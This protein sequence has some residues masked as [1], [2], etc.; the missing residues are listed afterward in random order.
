LLG[1]SA[2]AK[3]FECV[4]EVNECRAAALLAA[5]RPDR[6]DSK[7][8]QELAAEVA[9]LPDAPSPESSAAMLRP[10]GAHFIPAAFAY[11]DLLA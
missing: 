11:E 10:V 7:L 5:R 8:L 3:P 1:T 9:A 6:S 2:S 4:G